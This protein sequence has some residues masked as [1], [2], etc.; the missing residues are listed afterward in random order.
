MSGKQPLEVLIPHHNRAAS[1]RDALRSLAA[2]TRVPAICVVDN[3]STD[4]TREMLAGEFPSVRV[5]PLDRNLG[6][7][8]ALNRGVE[9]SAAELVVFLNN[10]AVA[11]ERFVEALVA[12][13]RESGAEAVAGVL[14]SPAG[15]VESAGVELDR[16]LNPYDAGHG[17][18]Y[19]EILASPPRP[20]GPSGGAALYVRSAF[21]AAGGFDER[22]FA[23]LEDAELGLRM[24]LLGMRCELAPQAFAWHHH[25]ATLGA[26]SA[27]K[28]ELLG[29]ARGYLLWKHGRALSL[30]ERLRG[31]AT[32]A[33][34]YAG[35][36]VIDRDLGA[37]RGRLRLRRELRGTPRPE[38]NPRLREL[39]LLRLGWRESLGRRLA[40]RRPS[41]GSGE[42][43][44]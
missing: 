5:V 17:M 38:G 36:A 32:D 7:G 39:P 9:T 34:V 41:A 6:F 20:L 35:K 42:G 22:L 43:G 16:A 18:R 8:A 13:Q 14:R 1:L 30:A 2:Q 23:Y 10:D 28:N 24:R 26:R 25:S 31:H 40:R 37:V 21:L 44:S 11:G 33:F 19:E 12:A 29:Y 15:W 27:A 3:A 4:E